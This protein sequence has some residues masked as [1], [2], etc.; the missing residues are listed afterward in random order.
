[1]LC[2]GTGCESLQRKFVR[3]A[4]PQPRPAPIFAFQ[5][6]TRTMTPLDR[7]RKHYAMFD[8]WNADLL[9]AV[10][11]RNVTQN[12]NPKQAQKASREALGELRI[13]QGLLQA[14]ITSQ[15][16]PLVEERVALDHQI[17]QGALGAAQRSAIWRALE[18]QSRQ[19]HRT[20][21]WRQV[22]DHLKPFDEAPRST[23]SA[24][25]PSGP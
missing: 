22:E 18:Q 9:D 6:Y 24:A 5:D 10:Q 14:E 4:K 3:K 7:Y 20:L 16:A 2:A 8:Y 21:Y 23:D 11:P 1:M 17:Q 19:I 15:V 25:E 13:L 12:F